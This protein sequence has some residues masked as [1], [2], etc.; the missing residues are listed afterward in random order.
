VYHWTGGRRL[1]GPTP[2]PS[3]PRPPPFLSPGSSAD[4]PAD[5]DDAVHLGRYTRT[6]S[7]RLESHSFSIFLLLFFF[8]LLPSCFFS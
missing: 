2:P 4:V 8:R 1:L 3:H 6:D 5:A 7:M